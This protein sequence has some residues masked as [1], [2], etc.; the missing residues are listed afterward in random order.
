MTKEELTEVVEIIYAMWNKEI[1]NLPDSR[2]NMYIAWFRVLNDTPKDGILQAA[3]RLAVRE[4][5][6]P[7]PGMIKAEYLR[8]LPEAPPTAAQAWNQYVRIRD[9]VNAGTTQHDVVIHPRL[10]ATI[11]QVGLNLHTNDD[12]RHFTETYSATVLS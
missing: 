12:R 5:Y 10:Q 8:T 2:K 11:Q 6:L 4:T 9:A 7:A 3:D 1:P